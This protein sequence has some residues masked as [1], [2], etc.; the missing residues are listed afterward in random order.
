MKFNDNRDIWLQPYAPVIM[1]SDDR[2]RIM[3]IQLG[4]YW[5]GNSN[6]NV[7]SVIL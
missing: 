7:L 6:Q 3:L 2:I 5:N 1:P 4:W